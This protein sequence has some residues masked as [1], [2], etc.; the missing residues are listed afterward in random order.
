MLKTENTINTQN[1]TFI[2]LCSMTM[3]LL[4]NPDQEIQLD[5]LTLTRTLTLD[6]IVPPC[7]HITPQPGRIG[8][9]NSNNNAPYKN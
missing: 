2:Y 8:C 6:H 9:D 5:L 7:Y 4:T 1:N 3:I